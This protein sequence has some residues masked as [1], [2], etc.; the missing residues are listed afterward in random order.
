M[1]KELLNKVQNWHQYCNFESKLEDMKRALTIL[2]LI[3]CFIGN[4]QNPQQPKML[5]Y[6]AKNIVGIFYYNLEEVVSKIKVKKDDTKNKVAKELR[7]YNNKVKDIEFL[8][9]VKLTEVETVVNNLGPQARTNADIR[10]RIRKLIETT[11]PPVRDSVFAREKA[12]N[13]NM[14]GIL[15]AKQYKKW[16]KY[17]KNKRESLLPKPPTQN[18]N[19]NIQ[20]NGRFGNRMGMGRRRF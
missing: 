9:S 1:Q 15:S 20:N 10:A 8:N 16:I 5:E 13:T 17:Q 7:S 11:I 18:R 6:K 2:F 3:S 4:A 14:E 19:R 12:L